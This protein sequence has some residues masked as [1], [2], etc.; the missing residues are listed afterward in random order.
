MNTPNLLCVV[1]TETTGLP[2]NPDARVIE[3]AATIWCLD[4]QAEVRSWSSL[5]RPS[6]WGEEGRRVARQICGI[7]PDLVDDLGEDPVRARMRL[8]D[9]TSGVLMHAWN[10]VFDEEMVRRMDPRYPHAPSRWG[11]CLMR[12]FSTLSRGNPDL[13]SKLVYAAEQCGFD[14]PEDAHR[15]L[16]D[17]RMAA[18]VICHV[19]NGGTLTG[20]LKG[21]T[22]YKGPG[23]ED[24]DA[25]KQ[26]GKRKWTPG[27]IVDTTTPTTPSQ[28]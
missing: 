15:A 22:A 24:P 4:R 10:S 11:P 8:L 28:E 2:D 18:R 14:V 17:A 23:S 19:R 27:G 16:T 26:G 25:P 20:R 7:D 12:E 13:R 21:P 1:D 5:V 6:T 3:V 9:F